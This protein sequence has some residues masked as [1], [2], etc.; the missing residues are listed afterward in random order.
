MGP[1]KLPKPANS[2]GHAMGEFRRAASGIKERVRKDHHQ[3]QQCRA[4]QSRYHTGKGY[5]TG[6]RDPH[7]SF[8]RIQTAS[9]SLAED[10][11]DKD[12]R[13]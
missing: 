8:L 5:L 7:Q 12:T 9:I 4:S 3:E 1:K 10:R 11:S 2:L 13:G 6:N